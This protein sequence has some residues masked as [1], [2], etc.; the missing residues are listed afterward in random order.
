MF[1]AVLAQSSM[2]S[3][4]NAFLPEI[5]LT[6]G[7]LLVV[8]IDLLPG[9]ADRR[10]PALLSLV[11]LLFAARTLWEQMGSGES[12]EAFGGL[13]LVDQ[14]AVFFK[15]FTCVAVTIVILYSLAWKRLEN[16]MGEYYLVLMSAVLGIF[17][18]VSSQHLLMVYIGLEL[19][20][21]P[22]YI[23]TGYFKGNLKSSEAS[24][25]YVIYGSVASGTMLYGFSLLYGLTGTLRLDEI[26]PALAQAF[27]ED[28][29]PQATG[30]AFLMILAGFGYKIAAVPFHYWLPDVYQGA[31][32]PITTF[33]AVAS[34]GAGFAILL[35]YMYLLYGS[36]DGLGGLESVD[37]TVWMDK[38]SLLIGVIAAVTMTLGNL[39]ALR[40]K[41][42]VRLF[43]YSSIAHAGYLLMGVAVI[44]QAGAEAV[45]FYLVAYLIMTLGAFGMII[46]LSNS[47]GSEEIEDFRGA[48]WKA[49]IVCGAFV[50]ML[51]SL[52]GLPPSAG[53]VGKW[54]LFKGV[55]ESGMLWL[56]VIAGLNSAVSLYYYFRLTKA[57]FLEK[58]EKEY[59]L[60]RSPV[61]SAIIIGLGVLVVYFGLSWGGLADLVQRAN[62]FA[63]AQ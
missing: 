63:L 11:G 57:L 49:P 13:F 30:L 4:I 25:K 60:K 29:N 7:L 5:Y 37:A 51:V 53:F 18:L 14:F 17:I 47:V 24:L 36:P 58:S 59:S 45:L 46:F 50:M 20:S 42:A 27:S 19:L 8:I 31:P 9:M 22:S 41:N 35:R 39:A 15:L 38:L 61:M 6:V 62:L 43:A 40:Q 16:R 10:I 33:L 44:N 28:G 3:D 52:V 55:V 54:Y 23:L 21:I 56:A 26:G 2:L 32:I 48:G 1:Q 34:K 12:V